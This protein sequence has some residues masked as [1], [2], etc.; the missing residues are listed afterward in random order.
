MKMIITLPIQIETEKY[1]ESLHLKSNF[2]FKF[3]I[4]L[5]YVLNKNLL[6]YTSESVQFETKFT[7]INPEKFFSL[8]YFKLKIQK[9]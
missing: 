4:K 7:D 8:F 3:A 1:F 5:V 9:L 2:L 6:V